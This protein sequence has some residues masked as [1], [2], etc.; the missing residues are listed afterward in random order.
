MTASFIVILLLMNEPSRHMKYRK[1]CENKDL[2]SL[3]LT[4]F[5]TPFLASLK[6]EDKNIS[7]QE[8]RFQSCCSTLQ[9][10]VSHEVLSSNHGRHLFHS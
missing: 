6:V 5:Y 9:D 8:V 3:R 4:L 1:V 10:I 7:L 2:F